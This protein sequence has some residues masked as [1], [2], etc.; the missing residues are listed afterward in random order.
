M[1]QNVAPEKD[2]IR[3]S[4]RISGSDD[5][6]RVRNCPVLSG[7]QKMFGGGGTLWNS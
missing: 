5:E 3:A 2:V 1:S 4:G 7:F 6:S